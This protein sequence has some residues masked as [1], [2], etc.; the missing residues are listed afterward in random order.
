MWW[1]SAVIITIK[2]M[3]DRKFFWS[4]YHLSSFFTARSSI[5]EILIY[6][7]QWNHSFVFFVRLNGM[8][9]GMLFF[10]W[11]LRVRKDECWRDLWRPWSWLCSRFFFFFFFGGEIVHEI[12]DIKNMDHIYFSWDHNQDV[13]ILAFLKHWNHIFIL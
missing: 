1:W 12:L 13:A 3:H 4:Y 7:Y 9:I 5:L 8:I 11:S 6:V 10:F 2:V